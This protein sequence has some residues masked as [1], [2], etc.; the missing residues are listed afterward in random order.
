MKQTNDKMTVLQAVRLIEQRLKLQKGDVTL[1]LPNNKLA[2]ASMTVGEL[3]SLYY[4]K[5]APLAESVRI[6][7]RPHVRG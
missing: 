3:R 1:R 5:K 2:P 4:S 7:Q 6:K